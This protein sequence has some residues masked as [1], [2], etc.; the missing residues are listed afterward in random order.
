MSMIFI[1]SANILLFFSACY[2]RKVDLTQEFSRDDLQNID[3]WLVFTLVGYI[4]MAFGMF[5][6]K[7]IADPGC[8]PKQDIESSDNVLG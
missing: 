2:N 3:T 8:L 5:N 1:F 6:I 7:A 4:I